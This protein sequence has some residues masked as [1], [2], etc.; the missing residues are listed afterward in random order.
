M[1][2]YTG[3]KNSLARREHVDLGLKTPGSHA[4]AQLLK[5]LNI[6]PGSHSHRGKGKMSDFGLQLREKQ[7]AKRIYGVLEKQ[8]RNYYE[9]ALKVSG[10]T[11]EVLLQQL[12]R[13]L[14]N[15]L[16]RLSIAPTRNLARQIVTH[17]HVCVN[18]QKVNIPSYQLQIDDVVSLT[19]RGMD[20]P[21]VSK[22]ITEKPPALP[23]WLE[24][25]GPVG[26]ML[27][28]PD[29]THITEEINEQLIVEYYSR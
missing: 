25:V 15:I 12:E 17:G 16:Y 19:K 20:I 6:I 2:R 9:K 11:G 8:F 24:R 27:H 21:A 28:I 29:R 1:A 10:N 13:R 18:N 14:D 22:L 7:K 5:R 23:D 26:K 3:P 4:H